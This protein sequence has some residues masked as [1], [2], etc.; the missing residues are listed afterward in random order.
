MI[1]VFDSNKL[2]QIATSSTRFSKVD[3]CVE[4]KAY[5][6]KTPVWGLAFMEGPHT[7]C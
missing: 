4:D 5:I 2:E 6:G 1:M 3:L 7:T